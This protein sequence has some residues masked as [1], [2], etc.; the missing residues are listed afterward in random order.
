MEGSSPS[1]NLATG[2]QTSR[3]GLFELRFNKLFV[4]SLF[5][6]ALLV[7][8]GVVYWPVLTYPFIQDDWG[9]L[10]ALVNG[11]AF[12]FFSNALSVKGKLF[13]RPLSLAYFVVY[14]R[15]FG[16]NPLPFHIIGLT[17]HLLNSLLVSLI[18][19]RLTRSHWISRFAGLIYAAAVTV[20]L[21]PLL[22]LVGFFR[23]SCCQTIITSTT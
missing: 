23:H 3:S 6:V 21:D 19:W 14:H 5:V 2:G 4:S 12:S 1:G 10:R 8:I 11:D 9:Q 13:F 7:A 20:H 15:L 18:S 17:I 16:L 22:W